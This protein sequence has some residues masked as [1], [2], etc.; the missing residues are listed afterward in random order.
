MM[1]WFDGR[2]QRPV[3]Q[4]AVELLAVIDE[5]TPDFQDDG[6]SMFPDRWFGFQFAWAGRIHDWEYCGRCHPA[7]YMNVDQKRAADKRIGR[8]VRSALPFRWRWLGTVVRVGVWRGGYGAYN[9]CGP[10]PDGATDEQ[11]VEGACRHGIAR[12]DWMT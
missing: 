5:T 9:S 6:L 3:P 12:P 10:V 8:L 4:E 1:G 11:L 2:S 7:G